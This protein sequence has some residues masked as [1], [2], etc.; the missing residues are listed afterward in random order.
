MPTRSTATLTPTL[1]LSQGEGANSIG[2]RLVPVIHV[3]QILSRSVKQV[4][5]GKPLAT[6]ARGRG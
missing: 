3:P 1:S 4:P 5:T 2:S 6:G